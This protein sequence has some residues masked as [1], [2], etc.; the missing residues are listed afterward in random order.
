MI[1]GALLLNRDEPIIK[2]VKGRVMKYAIVLLVSS[3][4]AY[5][6]KCLRM[7]PQE[8]S[9]YSF[10]RTLYGHQHVTALWYLYAYLSYLLMLPFLRKMAKNMTNKEFIW[11][12]LMYGAMNMLSILDFLL[13]KGT[14]GHN[15][16]FSFFITT[17]YVFYPLMGYF[18]EH[19]LTEKDFNLKILS[20]MVFLSFAAIVICCILS[21]YRSTLLDV[22]DEE[23]CQ[24]FFNTLIFIPTITV[25]YAAKM[26][27]MYHGISP[28]IRCV[29]ST[30][31]DTTFGLYLIEYLCR[32]ETK[33]IFNILKP[34]VHTLPACWIWISVAC[35]LGMTITY[36]VK[37]IPGMNKFV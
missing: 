6:Y 34:I 28:K 13:S 22:W 23:N 25:Y 19:R 21:Q 32:F 15:E 36:L 7:S 29:L 24:T 8:M 17:N 1:S 14:G 26:W 18:I 9:L 12:F 10:I 4:I 33:P 5:I 3:A 20:G 11:M 27:F 16:S 37:K 30:L 2:I 31:G 35:A